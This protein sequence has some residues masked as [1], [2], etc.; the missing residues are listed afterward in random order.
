MINVH[1]YRGT[2]SCQV[3]IKGNIRLVRRLVGGE[4]SERVEEEEFVGRQHRESIC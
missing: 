3:L 2:E 1:F 4:S